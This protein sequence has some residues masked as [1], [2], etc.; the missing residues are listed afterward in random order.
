MLSGFRLGAGL[1]APGLSL[2]AGASCRAISALSRREKEKTMSGS[3]PFLAQKKS[4]KSDP[5][6]PVPTPVPTPNCGKW[7]YGAMEKE[8]KKRKRGTNSQERGYQAPKKDCWAWWFFVATRRTGIV[9]LHLL[10]CALEKLKLNPVV[11]SNPF[12]TK[13]NKYEIVLTKWTTS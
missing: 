3:C 13:K 2:T 8:E 9:G 7:R 12:K 4:P 1:R 11:K 10:L 5:P 6:T